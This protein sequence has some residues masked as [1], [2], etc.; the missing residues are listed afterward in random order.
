MSDQD[1]DGFGL[2]GYVHSGMAPSGALRASPG[3]SGTSE[4]RTH[5]S[6]AQ[7]LESSEFQNNSVI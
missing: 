6:G 1:P 5:G 4:V 7:F 3:Q 2:P